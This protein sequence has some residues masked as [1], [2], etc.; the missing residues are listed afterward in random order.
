SVPSA[1]VMYWLDVL[2]SSNQYITSAD[3]TLRTPTGDLGVT[4]I[5]VAGVLNPNPTPAEF[6]NS[7]DS[8]V[9]PYCRSDGD[10]SR[11]VAAGLGA[12][13]G[14]GLERSESKFTPMVN[15]QYDV[16]DNINSYFSWSEGFKG[17]G[18]NGQA[19][20]EQALEYEEETVE[21][22]ELGLKSTLFDG[23]MTANV[24]VYHSTYE[25]FQT[26]QFINQVFIVGNAGEV[27]S[28]GIEA[29][30]LWQATD[31]LRLGF[32][33][34][35]ADVQYEDFPNAAC[36]NAQQTALN[37]FNGERAM[38]NT[39]GVN[40]LSGREVENAPELSGNLFA[41]LDVP[42]ANQSFDAQLGADISYT[43]E[44]FLSQNLDPNQ[45]QDAYSLVN[46]RASLLDKDEKWELALLGRNVTDEIYLLTAAGVPAQFGADFGS[47]SRGS[48]VEVQFNW[49][50][51]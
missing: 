18:F 23:S 3:G 40:D 28:Q 24:A 42:L 25:D 29:D 30:V 38:C 39:N 47:V 37:P 46:L 51:R 13:C 21:A 16:S 6:A 41:V 27:T 7:F 12:P 5:V 35:W 44:H 34:A 48:V 33:G 31:T 14:P 45:F 10:T 17:G 11:Y 26:T 43:G 4:P 36:T 22:F 9:V 20:R 32:S 2:V 50:F 1:L 49:F 19:R 15:L 8:T